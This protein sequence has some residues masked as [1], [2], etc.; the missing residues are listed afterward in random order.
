MGHVI[1]ACD[2]GTTV[3]RAVAVEVLDDGRLAVLGAASER[4]AGFQDGDFVDLRAG[5][6]AIQRTLRALESAAELEVEAFF[7]N[8]AGPHLRSVWARGQVQVGSAPRA[9]RDRDIEAVI[10]K[11]RSLAIP[12]DHQILAVN[13]V[14]YTVDRVGNIVDPRG[15]TGSQLEVQAHLITG[16]RSVVRNVEQAIDAAGYTAAGHAVD[17]LAAAAC[18]VSE[19]EKDAGVLLVDIGGL[20]TH[21]A[22]LRAGRLVGVGS[23]PWGGMHL[24][25]DLSHGLRVELDAAERLKCARGVALRSLVESASLDVLFDDDRPQETPGLV[26]AILEPRLEEILTL[27]KSD[28]GSDRPLTDLAAGLILTG[29]GS[30]CDGSVPL[31]EEVFGMSVQPRFL[32]D[33]LPGAEH[34]GEGQWATALGLALWA[35]A[36][37][38][39]P[40]APSVPER[41]TRVV[42]RLKNWLGGKKR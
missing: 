42:D 10:A 16:S 20:A 4:A 39:E 36:G 7:H 1:V 21:W 35:G 19:A 34:L 29:G 18:L 32:P 41:S 12:F 30:R 15:R 11:A 8:V 2:F 9:I 6:R 23:V 25:R 14:S 24:T 26:A 40:Q 31:C 5:S 22:M 27:V 3:F 28:L 33:D 17:V 13:P 37:A 38:V